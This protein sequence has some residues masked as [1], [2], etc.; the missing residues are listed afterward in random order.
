MWRGRRPT[1]PACGWGS[2]C[3][4]GRG[5]GGGGGGARGVREGEVRLEYG[6][7]VAVSDGGRSVAWA[8]VAA[9]GPV[10]E[11]AAY[12]QEQVEVTCFT[13]QVAEVE[14]DPETGQVGVRRLVTA[15][16]VGTII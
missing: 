9:S 6:R 12:R 10:E 16:D 11:R 7:F 5:G 8:E 13:V 14:V 1:R 15:H 2:G 3:G 4:G